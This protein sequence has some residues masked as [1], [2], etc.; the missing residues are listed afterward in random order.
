MHLGRAIL[1]SSNLPAMFYSESQLTATY[2]HNRTVHGFDLITPYEHI[3]RRAS[4]VSHLRP[5]GC[6]AY[7]HVPAELRSKL[8]PSG[9]KRRLLGYLDD[10]DSEELMGYK[11]LRESDLA[12]L[13]CRDVTFNENAA[14]DPLPQSELY[15][16]DEQG[17]NLF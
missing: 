10:D 7:A 16:D 15:L 4:V 5:F 9:Q 3:Y 13:H 17:D 2:L 12:I 14:M 6:V 8:E 11:L 1:I